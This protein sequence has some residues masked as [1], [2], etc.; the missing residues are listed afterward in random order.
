MEFGYFDTSRFVFTHEDE[1]GG[2]VK[3]FEVEFAGARSESYRTV[4]RKPQ[5]EPATLE[6]DLSRRDFTVNAM[7]Q[8]VGS[9]GKLGKVKD[10]FKGK[11]DLQ[12]KIL[13]TPLDPDET[14]HDD[15]LRMMRAARFAAQLNFSI[16]PDA[17]AA[18]ERNAERLAIISAER[19]Q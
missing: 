1:E 18:I 6:Q 4:S 12:D 7:A 9:G 8:K 2:K 16:D 13:R 17:L 11:K 3:D 19:I 10:I 14:F 15:P 5:V